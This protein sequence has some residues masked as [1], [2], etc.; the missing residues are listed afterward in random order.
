[1]CWNAA[2]SIWYWKRVSLF[3]P[4][5]PSGA[6]PSRGGMCASVVAAAEEAAVEVVETA[7]DVVEVDVAFT[8]EVLFV[9]E[10]S[11]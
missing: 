8:V 6:T 3:R 2:S 11:C 1:M 5:G 9:E 4:T 7:A 10:A